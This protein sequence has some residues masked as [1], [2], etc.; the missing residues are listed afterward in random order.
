MAFFSLLWAYFLKAPGVSV[1]RTRCFP[2]YRH[3]FK[4]THSLPQLAFHPYLPTFPFTNGVSQP[5][6]SPAPLGLCFWLKPHSHFCTSTPTR[7]N[8]NSSASRTLSD[9]PTQPAAATGDAP[10]SLSP[11]D[12]I[13]LHYFWA[14]DLFSVSLGAP[15]GRN[16][17]VFA[18]K[19][20]HSVWH[21]VG[22]QPLSKH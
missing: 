22:P 14:W 20:P 11:Q 9:L 17:G 6:P 13:L 19:L 18:W 7:P 2:R 3:P 1:D 12:L 5:R 16:H 4:D 21:T 15:R 10:L 8:S